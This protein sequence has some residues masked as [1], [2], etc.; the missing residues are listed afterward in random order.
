MLRDG[1]QSSQALVSVAGAAG[2][3]AAK[4]SSA[5]WVPFVGPIVAGVGIALGF[6]FNR[7][8]PK[9]KIATTA[10]V[11]DLEPLLK[12]NLDGYLSGPRTK[13]S[14][15]AALKNFDDA[16]TFLTS[17]AG[18]GNRDMGNPGKACIA[19]RSRSGRWDWFSYYRDP[20]ATDQAKEDTFGSMLNV[21]GMPEGLENALLP[22]GLILLALVM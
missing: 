16:W 8:G 4:V 20:I 17:S 2:D 19:D 13:T 1:T 9:Q 11:N 14:Q 10:I 12:Q 6:I 7:K 15:A 5:A 3:I 22:A 21:A 18:C